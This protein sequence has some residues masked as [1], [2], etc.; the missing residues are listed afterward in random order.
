M[1]GL[2][3]ALLLWLAFAVL[4]DAAILLAV[5]LLSEYPLERP[6]LLL[7]LLNPVDLARVLLLLK[8]DVAALMGYTGATLQRFFGNATGLL[9][10]GVALVFWTLGPL[11]L[12]SRM[13][14]R[15]DF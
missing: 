5:T 2:G 3:G 13:F 4:Y 10:T 1:R 8:L 7:V 11:L 12:G 15:K 14:V 6:L 9:V